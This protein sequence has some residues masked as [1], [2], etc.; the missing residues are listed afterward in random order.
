MTGP[1]AVW[2]RSLEEDARAITLKLCDARRPRQAA[3]ANLE[4]RSFGVRRFIMVAAV[5]TFLFFSF[6]RSPQIR[7]KAIRET[8]QA[9][10]LS[11]PD[12]R[13][14][15]LLE[16]QP[17]LTDKLFHLQ[18]LF[19]TKNEKCHKTTKTSFGNC[20]DLDFLHTSQSITR[21]SPCKSRFRRC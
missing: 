4:G 11:A 7:R 2:G 10:I 15:V 16:A 21:S 18:P 8:P 13:L 1:M 9:L 12:L 19:N 5:C 6:R 17:R 14:H 3:P 20:E